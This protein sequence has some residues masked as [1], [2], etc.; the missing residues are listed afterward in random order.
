MKDDEK[1][2]KVEVESRKE[3]EKG[4]Q[5]HEKGNHG[6]NL[7]YNYSLMNCSLLWVQE[8]H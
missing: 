1:A 8:I 2:R 3:K 6:G 7:K 4:R 5:D